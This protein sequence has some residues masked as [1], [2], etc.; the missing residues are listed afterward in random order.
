MSLYPVPMRYPVPIDGSSGKRAREENRPL[1]RNEYIDVLVDVDRW[2]FVKPGD[3][4]VF[5][6]MPVADRLSYRRAFEGQVA[7]AKETPR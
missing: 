2:D 4:E 7:L 1:A 3:R 5:E 6:S